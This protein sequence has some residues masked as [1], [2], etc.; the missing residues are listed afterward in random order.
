[1]FCDQRIYLKALNEKILK[2]KNSNRKS[3]HRCIQHPSCKNL[4]KDFG[5]LWPKSHRKKIF[6]APSND[7]SGSFIPAGI[8][9]SISAPLHL[10][11]YIQ[12]QADSERN[13]DDLI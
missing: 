7:V 9:T 1:M 2:K 13:I 12:A 11:M 4:L 3:I 10:F 5:I 6:L 8:I